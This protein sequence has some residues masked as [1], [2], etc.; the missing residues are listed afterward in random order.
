MQI[1]Y[2]E[3]STRNESNKFIGPFH[4]VKG[5]RNPIL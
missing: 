1:L 3:Q 5:S 4:T 2:F